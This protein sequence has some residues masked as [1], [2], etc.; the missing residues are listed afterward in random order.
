MLCK[1]KVHD[2][3]NS[4]VFEMEFYNHFK[5]VSRFGSIIQLGF[6]KGKL[7]FQQHLER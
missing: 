2:S 5:M 3:G 4:D 7:I 1:R 6:L